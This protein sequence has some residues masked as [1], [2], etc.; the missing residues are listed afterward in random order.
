MKS[1]GLAAALAA[2]FSAAPAFAQQPDQLK[3]AYEAGRNQLGILGYCSDKGFVGA[4]VV[5]VQRKLLGIIPVPADKSGGDAAEA[6]GKKGTFA[7]MGMT[8]DI[9]AIAKAQNST[10][11]AF[12][13][14]V[15]DAIKAAA[16][17]L[18]K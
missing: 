15:G 18:P 3:I 17:Q 2:G 13:K 10:P 8:Q 14:T 5:D 9:E 7:A 6:Q 1:L 4:D 11:A 12:C 16:A